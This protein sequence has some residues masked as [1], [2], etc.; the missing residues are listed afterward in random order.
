MLPS[1]ILLG[2]HGCDATIAAGVVS[3]AN[4][5]KQSQNDYDWLG[6]GAYFWEGNP[7]RA[8]RWAEES[9]QRGKIKKPAVLGAVI[10]PG[11]CLDLIEADAGDLIKAAYNWYHELCLASGKPEVRNTGRDFKARYLD[12]AVFET[13]HRLREEEGASPFDTVR[14]FFVEGSELYPGAGIRDRDHI[15]I[16]VRHPKQIL[17][18]FIPRH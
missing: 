8:L 9:H 16:C 2:F 15:Q 4:E 12:C 10:A 17:G 5:L 18:Y 14:G 7:E 3:G 6:H 1:S 11:R 13:L